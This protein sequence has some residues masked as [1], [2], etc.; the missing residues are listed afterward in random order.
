MVT[1]EIINHHIVEAS[2]TTGRLFGDNIFVPTQ[3]ALHNLENDLDLTES[4]TLIA[5]G[6]THLALQDSTARRGGTFPT[7]AR[8][9]AQDLGP[10]HDLVPTF[11]SLGH[12]TFPTSVYESFRTNV[13]YIV[14]EEP[15]EHKMIQAIRELLFLPVHPRSS[16]HRTHLIGLHRTIL[17]EPTPSPQSL[18]DL[19]HSTIGYISSLGGD[20]GGGTMLIDSEEYIIL[21]REVEGG[22]A[23]QIT[24]GDHGASTILL[25]HKTYSTHR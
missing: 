9:H 11:L 3:V 10:H 21:R 2:N 16:R 12:I 22:Q 14:A 19:L 5:D 18:R 6:L 24:L 15:D 13:H 1:N 4:V 7:R 23:F 20:A 25:D 8:I 17:N